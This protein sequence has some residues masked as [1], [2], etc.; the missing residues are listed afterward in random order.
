MNKR[1]HGI[2]RSVPEGHSVNMRHSVDMDYLMRV[3]QCLIQSL[4][5]RYN[6]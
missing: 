5:G 2:F 4:I 1:R 6:R 3:V